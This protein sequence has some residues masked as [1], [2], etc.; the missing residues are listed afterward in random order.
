MWYQLKKGKKLKHTRRIKKKKTR[1]IKHAKKSIKKLKQRKKIKKHTKKSPSPKNIN[2]YKRWIKILQYDLKERNSTILELQKQYDERSKWALDLDKKLKQSDETI[3]DLQKQFDERTKWTNELDNKLKQRDE[4]ITNLQKQFD[5]RSNWIEDQDKKSKQK[6]ST[7]L[8]LQKQYDERSK[9]ALELDKK[10]KQSDETIID[11]Q[12]QFDE[13]TSW[14]NELDNKLKQRD[15]KVSELQKQ[16]DEGKN[17]L[18]NL[19]N[20]NDKIKKLLQTKES[21]LNEAKTTLQT[22]ESELNEAKITLQTKDSQFQNLQNESDAK[23]RELDLIRNSVVFSITSGIAQKLGKIAPKSTRRGDALK[24]VADA[25]TMKKKNGSKTIL[26]AVASKVTKKK[27]RLGDSRQIPEV[28]LKPIIR[29]EEYLSSKTIKIDEKFEPDLQLRESL[30]FGNHNISNLSRFPKISI[31]IITL[32]QLEAL[33]RNLSSIEERSTYKNYEIIIVTNNHDENSEMRKFLKTVKHSVYVYDDEY[34]FGAMNNFGA[35]KADGEFLLFLNDD[36]QVS[37]PNWLE[38]FLSLGLKRNTGVVGAKLLSPNGKLQDCGGIVWRNGNAWNYGRNYEPE[39]PKFNYVRDIDYCSG[40]CLF[41]K[42]VIFN[43][44]GGFDSR[45]DP[46]YWED[47]DLCFSIRKLGYR[48]LYQPLAKLVHY[49]GMTQ[50]TSTDEGLKSNQV[51][52]P[53]LCVHQTVFEDRL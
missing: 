31:I 48:V 19:K 27:L 29:N 40:S 43:Q 39:D 50:G 37:E 11:L 2:G 47:T 53:N 15:E 17:L 3:I 28:Y 35:S 30:K 13:R 8:E 32:N 16:Y 6:D 18:S 23:Q 25:Y 42:K 5:E 36:M 1:K 14:A 44:V 9:W 7:I 22:K 26:K 24:M 12:K 4:T 52:W 33:K 20:E 34:S 45:F 49:E 38:A 41:V 21:E 10:L 51:H 46:A